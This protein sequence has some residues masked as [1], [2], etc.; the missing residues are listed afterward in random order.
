[1]EWKKKFKQ[2]K[3]GYDFRIKIVSS[4]RIKMIQYKNK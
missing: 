1:M 4:N 2:Q 3:T